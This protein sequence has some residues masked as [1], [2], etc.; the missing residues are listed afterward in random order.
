[1]CGG[2]DVDI[3][4]YMYVSSL[5]KGTLMS[6]HSGIAAAMS[7]TPMLDDVSGDG[8][9]AWNNKNPPQTCQLSRQASC[10]H[11]SVCRP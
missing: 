8:G 10:P 11:A 5:L 1:M 7:S 6:C 4:I 3:H 9:A 2:G